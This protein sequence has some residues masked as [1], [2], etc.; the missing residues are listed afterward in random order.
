M[1][2]IFWGFFLIFVNF[3]LSVSGHVLNLLP[4]FAGYL[5]VMR[6]CRELEGES[7]LFASIRPF[8]LGMAVY[9]GIL[10]LGDLLAVTGQ[11]SWLAVLLGLLSLAVSLYVSWAVVQAIRDAEVRR[12]AELNGDSLKTAWTV[13]AVA[14]SASWVLAILG[15]LLALLGVIAG[16]AGIV[17]F[18]AALWRSWKNY[19]A[20]PPLGG[21][22][23]D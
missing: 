6:G 13:L 18:L 21:P 20:L 19:E 22:A 12:S 15:S 8:A 17:W 5:L 14:E 1:S 7:G 2:S 10:W 23:L 16:L 11:G 3:Y 9:T 4:P